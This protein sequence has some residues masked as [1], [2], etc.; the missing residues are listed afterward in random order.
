MKPTLIALLALVLLAGC[1]TPG[2]PRKTITLDLPPVQY[3]K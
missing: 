3:E 2:S 1:A